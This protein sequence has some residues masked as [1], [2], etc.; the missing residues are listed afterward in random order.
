MYNP[1]VNQWESLDY[2]VTTVPKSVIYNSVLDK[3]LVI[4]DTEPVLILEYS[5]KDKSWNN[6]S[7][8]VK[9]ILANT[10][11][12]ENGQYIYIGNIKV[13]DLMSNGITN[14]KND[15]ITNLAPPKMENSDKLVTAVWDNERLYIAGSFSD[16]GFLKVIKNNSFEII[17]YQPHVTGDIKTVHYS[18]KKKCL[19][20]GGNFKVESK[21]FG[22]LILNIELL[23]NVPEYSLGNN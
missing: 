20:L 5:F 13:F 9:G 16:N 2:N 14:V 21:Y 12:V 1:S 4:V 7:I 19:F 10:V 8:I 3:L 11:C 17:K 15:I 23:N 18:D 6:S 22:V